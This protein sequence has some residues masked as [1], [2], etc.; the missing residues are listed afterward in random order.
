MHPSPITSTRTD[1]T[2]P[3]DRHSL[4]ADGGLLGIYNA[5]TE[6]AVA[7][8]ISGGTTRNFN[9]KNVGTEPAGAMDAINGS[10]KG[11]QWDLAQKGF[12]I[13]Q[14]ILQT[15]FTNTGLKYADTLKVNTTQYAPSGRL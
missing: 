1:P 10:V 4:T 7:P 3:I 8:S 14:Q 11:T 9:A 12:K 15:Q 2:A 5:S 13:K 6:L